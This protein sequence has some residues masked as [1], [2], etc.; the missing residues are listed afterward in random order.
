MSKS[1]TLEFFIN[2]IPLSTKVCP[3]CSPSVICFNRFYHSHL[4]LIKLLSVCVYFV[5]TIFKLVR[6]YSVYRQ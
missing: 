2:V 1:L 4:F 5:E 3:L 6:G